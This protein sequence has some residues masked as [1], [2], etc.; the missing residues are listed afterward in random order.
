MKVTIL[1]GTPDEI[2]EY[3]RKS[4][5]LEPEPPQLEEKHKSLRQR[6]NLNTKKLRGEVFQETGLPVL[7][8]IRKPVKPKGKR[9]VLFQPTIAGNGE[10]WKQD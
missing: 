3:Q 6:Y 10:W 1:E 8:N 4:V 2:L 5:S 7:Q 9:R